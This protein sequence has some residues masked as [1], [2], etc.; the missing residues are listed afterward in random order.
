MHD[1]VT[2]EYC[3]VTPLTWASTRELVCEPAMQMIA[4]GVGKA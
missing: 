4:E 3:D 2:H 1:T